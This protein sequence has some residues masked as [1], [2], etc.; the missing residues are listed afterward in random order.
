V[1]WLDLDLDAL[2]DRSVVPRRPEQSRPLSRFPSSDIDLAFIVPDLVP[3]A[4]VEAT[5]RRSGGELLESVELFDVYRGPSLP[6]GSRSL[7]FRLRFCA[8]DR[9][10]TDDEVGELRS[11]AID[12]VEQEHQAS[13][14]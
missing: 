10:L 2:L 7:A 12:A 4:A 11:R 6:E 13:L 5:V 14:R 1:G 8:L 3:A 9:T